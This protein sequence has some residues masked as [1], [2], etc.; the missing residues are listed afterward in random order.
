MEA[1]RQQRE[2]ERRQAEAADHERKSQQFNRR[3]QSLTVDAVESEP[4]YLKAKGLTGFT[5]PH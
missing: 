3:W 2:Q 4:E 5:F 1:E